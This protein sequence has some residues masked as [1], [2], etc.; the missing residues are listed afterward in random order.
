MIAA[1][2]GPLYQEGD[3]VTGGERCGKAA[4]EAWNKRLGLEVSRS[5]LSRQALGGSPPTARRVAEMRDA[6]EIV[7]EV[8]SHLLPGGTVKLGPFRKVQD[9]LRSRT[10][11]QLARILTSPPAGAIPPMRMPLP[12]ARTAGRAGFQ[13]GRLQDVLNQQ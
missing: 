3:A 5:E 2:S 11:Q 6:S 1:Q 7:T 8:A 13:A 9:G 4:A 12:S 10:D